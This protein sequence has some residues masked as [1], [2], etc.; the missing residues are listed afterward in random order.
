MDIVT[1]NT[2]AKLYE[3]IS[4]F[5][6]SDYS[7]DELV[8]TYND[9]R[10]QANSILVIYPV[11]PDV[12]S[13]INDPL[14]GLQSIRKWCEEAEKTVDDIVYS[15]GRQTIR[16]VISQFKKLRGFAS[17]VLSLV[18]KKLQ[19]ETRAKYAKKRAQEQARFQA[20]I[21]RRLLAKQKTSAAAS[22]IKSDVGSPLVLEAQIRADIL[23]ET[24]FILLPEECE[25]NK[26][27]QSYLSKDPTYN[28]RLS[29][30]HKE[31]CEVVEEINKLIS[32]KTPT[33]KL[34]D[35]YC[36]LKNIPLQQQY[37][38]I[39]RVYS[40]QNLADVILDNCSHL[41]SSVDN[42]IK[43]LEN[44][45]AKTETGQNT[46]TGTGGKQ[47][48]SKLAQKLIRAIDQATELAKEVY[49]CGDKS[50][51]NAKMERLGGEINALAI[52][53]GLAKEADPPYS[54]G[55]LSWHPSLVMKQASAVMGG[56]ERKLFP[57]IGRL[58][59]L[60]ARAELLTEIG[61]E[62]PPTETLEEDIVQKIKPVKE[63]SKETAQK[64]SAGEQKNPD[65]Y[66]VIVGKGICNIGQSVK[67]L[68]QVIADTG[69]QGVSCSERA[70][71]SFKK[72]FREKDY[73]K[74][75]EQFRWDKG[76]QKL[77]TEIPVG[78]L[79]IKKQ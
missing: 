60:R 48:K 24:G 63:L 16:K 38:E 73:S 58:S 3:A 56:I 72:F 45:Q 53:C 13:C 17:N 28:D 65:Y 75:I 41:Y 15:L 46:G 2:P 79:F 7:Q 61:S 55:M 57:E 43:T 25:E 5:L 20:E 39:G 29:Q 9:A 1:A 30:P 31:I 19:N 71:K 11:L 59:T 67:L 47:S 70:W 68:E 26:A 44:I 49:S 66:E 18:D 54:P 62:H 21:D 52:E 8:K 69:R 35:I 6:Q 50:E 36:K 27:V 4:Q 42:V 22:G 34:L 14:D 76:E 32:S 77:H 10:K 74:M 23:E 51:Y 40:L 37:N 12:P 78:K 64:E 33:G